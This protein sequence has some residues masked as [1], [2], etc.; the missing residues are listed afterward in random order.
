MTGVLYLLLNAVA[1]RIQTG[2]H[3]TTIVYRGALQVHRAR[4]IE[5]R[6]RHRPLVTFEAVGRSLLL[7]LAVT[8][9]HVDIRSAA[10]VTPRPRRRCAVGTLR[11]RRV[12]RLRGR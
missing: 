11:R 1:A 4:R 9:I 10:P 6:L 5:A 2:A 7:V 8:R 3:R 12:V